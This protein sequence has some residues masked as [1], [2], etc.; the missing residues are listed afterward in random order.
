MHNHLR[1]A[2]LLVL[3]VPLSLGCQA[4]NFGADDRPD[5]FDHLPVVAPARQWAGGEI[6]MA[7]IAFAGVDLG[8]LG[9][10]VGGRPV[11]A[12]RIT[13]DTIQLRL[14]SEAGSGVQSITALYE[15]TR[16]EIATVE[17]VG[18]AGTTAITVQAC[19]SP[20]PWPAEQPTGVLVGGCGPDAVLDLILTNGTTR[21]FEGLFN[22]GYSPSLSFRDRGLLDSRGLVAQLDAN[23][24]SWDSLGVGPNTGGYRHL[25]EL[26]AGVWLRTSNH[27]GY[28]WQEG[29]STQT[30]LELE[31]EWRLIRSPAASRATFVVSAANPSL[32]ILN[33]GTGEVATWVA[34]IKST[35]GAAFGADG[36]F[37][38]LLGRPEWCCVAHLRKVDVATGTITAQ[39]TT[40]DGGFDLALDQGA[41]ELLFELDAGEDRWILRVRN[42]DDLAVIGEAVVLADPATFWIEP[43]LVVE[44]AQHRATIFGAEAGGALKFYRFDLLVP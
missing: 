32:P 34:G 31:S 20:I 44:A 18:W 9:L 36:N 39:D 37:L 3:V 16:T 24:E 2:G 6:R 26:A 29:D 41:P 38:Y 19:T 43:T 27:L 30:I 25:Y 14:P 11:T 42:A 17:A 22:N 40:R 1:A 8:D 10:E 15:G 13:D 33:T 7:S 4:E 21:R 35:D 28:L 23:L 5:L 12:T